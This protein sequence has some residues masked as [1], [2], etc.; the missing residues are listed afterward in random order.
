MKKKKRPSNRGKKA[1]QKSLHC[2]SAISK[3]TFKVKELTKLIVATTSLVKSIS[4]GLV[5][6]K[7][8]YDQF[9][10]YLKLVWEWIFG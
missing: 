10:P 2:P 7:S 5:V 6:A 9:K 3:K 1:K 8:A 4:K